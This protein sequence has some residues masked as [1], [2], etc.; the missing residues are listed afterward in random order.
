MHRGRQCVRPHSSLDPGSGEDDDDATR[1]FKK[2]RRKRGGRPFVCSP[3]TNRKPLLK[4]ESKGRGPRGTNQSDGLILFSTSA[5]IPFSE[6]NSHIAL[7]AF[8]VIAWAQ[9]VRMFGLRFTSITGSL[10]F[11]NSRSVAYLSIN[12]SRVKLFSSHMSPNSSSY[13]RRNCLTMRAWVSRGIVTDDIVGGQEKNPQRPN[14]PGRF[15]SHSRGRVACAPSRRHI[16]RRKSALLCR[17]TLLVK[18]VISLCR[19]RLYDQKCRDYCKQNQSKHSH[20]AIENCSGVQR[21]QDDVAY[22]EHYDSAR[23]LVLFHGQRISRDYIQPLKQCESEQRICNIVF[24]L[25][26]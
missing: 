17:C 16:D 15:I 21:T 23:L 24:R 6:H 10:F 2:V 4:K 3:Q 26:I 7:C 22:G 5:W 25:L 11:Q 12:S 8:V 1:G 14:S 20:F 18:M 13:S 9:M 19:M